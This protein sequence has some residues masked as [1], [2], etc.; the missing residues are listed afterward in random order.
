MFKHDVW[1]W[2]SK[3]KFEHNVWTWL[4]AEDKAEFDWSKDKLLK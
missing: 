2:C 4:W 1:S 3:M